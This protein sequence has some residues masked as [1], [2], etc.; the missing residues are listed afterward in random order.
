M[1]KRIQVPHPNQ[2]GVCLLLL[3]FN[4]WTIHFSSGFQH[5]RSPIRL[6]KSWLIFRSKYVGQNEHMG[7][8]ILCFVVMLFIV[9]GMIVF[10][11]Y[12]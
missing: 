10:L 7:D 2:C 4:P 11:T 3:S 6:R 8:G 1:G 9:H 12:L 5:H